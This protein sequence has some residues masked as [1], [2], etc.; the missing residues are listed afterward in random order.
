MSVKKER[1][2][3]L[4][5]YNNIMFVD[6]SGDDGIV[7]TENGSSKSF[8]VACLVIQSQ[9]FQHNCE[10]LNRVKRAIGAS[11]SQEVKSS[12]ILRHKNKYRVFQ[13]LK[14]L[15]GT[16]YAMVAYKMEM[17]SMGKLTA[18][19][20]K[21]KHLTCMCH[22]FPIEVFCRHMQSTRTLILIDNMKRIEMHLVS[23]IINE[24]QSEVD[25]CFV[26]SKTQRFPLMQLADHLAGI[27]R[28]FFERYI[29]TRGFQNRCVT[30]IDK[31]STS[32]L[33]KDPA[34]LLPGDSEGWYLIRNLMERAPDPFADNLL[35][36][37]SERWRSFEALTC[38]RK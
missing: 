32:K 12:A 2:I 26:D 14:H 18:D 34:S 36:W 16:L 6:G 4:D 7:F 8:V 24:R 15:R 19:M 27:T 33:C 25:F 35:I 31:N 30:C 9:D 13:E 17:H 28:D 10:V 11:P 1:D 21:K 5:D 29:D 23:S 3:N 20:V 22:N 38:R 37:P